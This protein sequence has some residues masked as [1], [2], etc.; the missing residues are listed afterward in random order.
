[1][2]SGKRCAVCGVG[3]LQ[4]VS[5]WTSSTVTLGAISIMTTP[6]THHT[7]ASE[8]ATQRAAVM[9]QTGG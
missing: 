7:H 2:I 4:P 1:M 8:Q 9:R 6:C 3:T 5:A